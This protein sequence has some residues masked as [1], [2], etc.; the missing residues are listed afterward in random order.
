MALR[1][2]ASHGLEALAGSRISVA[3]LVLIQVNL[4]R[5]A[6]YGYGDVASYYKE[7]RKYCID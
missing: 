1:K 4:A 5:Q 6:R 3:G 7:Y 2:V